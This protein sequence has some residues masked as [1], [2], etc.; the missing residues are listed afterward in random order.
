MRA[1]VFSVKDKGVT[2]PAIAR[3]REDGGYE[4]V[5]GHRRQKASELA[6]YADMPGIVRNLTDDEGA[7]YVKCVW[8]DP[9]LGNGRMEQ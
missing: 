3:P 4:I 1:M 2:Q 6:G 5:S 7:L 9:R 8:N